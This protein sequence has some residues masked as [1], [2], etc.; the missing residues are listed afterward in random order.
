MQARDYSWDV[1]VVGAWN[2]AILTP[3]GIGRRIFNLAE[4]QA[5]QVD[6]PMNA[7]VGPFVRHGGQIVRVTDERLSI[8]PE[9]V[10]FQSIAESMQLAKRPMQSLRETPFRAAGINY[11][12][13]FGDTSDEFLRI[14]R[15]DL[16][17]FLVDVH[18]KEVRSRRL[19]RSA[20]FADG[21]INIDLFEY[22]DGSSAIMFNFHR[23]T[24]QLDDLLQWLDG[25][26]D[27]HRAFINSV[28]E[29]VNADIRIEEL[30]GANGND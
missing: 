10:S 24:S 26:V 13:I 11:R 21:N 19:R 8:S 28:C 12:F 1:V 17:E 23:E 30:Q 27:D 2:T 14:T 18:E 6:V 20:S 3:Q 7:N 9:R 4:G 22:H 5:V 25:P 29:H 15:T 16:D